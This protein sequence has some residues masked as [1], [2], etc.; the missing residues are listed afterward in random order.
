[1]SENSRSA[2]PYQRPDEL[3]WR[4]EPMRAAGDFA[5]FW[6][7][8]P[9]LVPTV[10]GDGHGVLVIPGFLA[11]DLSTHVLRSVVQAHGYHA[12]GWGLG[13]N[14]GPTSRLWS[15][16]GKRLRRLQRQTGRPVTLIGQSLGGVFARELAREL[17]EAVRQVITLGAPYRLTTEDAPQTTMAGHLYHALRDLHAHAFGG[18]EREEERVPLSVPATSI[19]SRADGVVPWNSC[20]DVERPR[21]ENLEVAASHCGMGMHP[22]ML[23]IVLDRLRQPE[24]EWTPYR[25]PQREPFGS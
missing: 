7:A 24:G 5:A 22:D 6:A 23:R 19:Y 20:V 2:P 25:S 16:V 14:I 10:P 9:A 12:V 3:L 21:S 17:P 15:G 18:P 13:P 8:L 1:M 4:T 11:D